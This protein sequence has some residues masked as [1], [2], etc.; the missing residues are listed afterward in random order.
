MFGRKGAARVVRAFLI[1]RTTEGLTMIIPHLW[2]L[3]KSDSSS[4]VVNPA[5]SA[6]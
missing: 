6:L 2:P 1:D 5:L 4:F 3:Q